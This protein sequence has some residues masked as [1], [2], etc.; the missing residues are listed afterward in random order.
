MNASQKKEDVFR[1]FPLPRGLNVG[2]FDRGVCL[3]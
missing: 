3:C 2:N 1:T